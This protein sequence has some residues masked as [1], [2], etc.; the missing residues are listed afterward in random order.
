MAKRGRPA[1]GFRPV[2]FHIQLRLAPG[3]DD[4]VIAYLQ[5]APPRL[6]AQYVLRAMQAGALAPLPATGAAEDWRFDDL[7]Q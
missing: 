4:A 1:S 2:V 6:R 3:Q 5:S 7:W